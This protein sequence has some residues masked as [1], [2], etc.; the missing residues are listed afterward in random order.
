MSALVIKAWRADTKPID[1]ENNYV[2]ILGRKGGL[3]AWL[4]SVLGLDSTTQI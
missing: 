3:L 2:K 1:Q 4:L